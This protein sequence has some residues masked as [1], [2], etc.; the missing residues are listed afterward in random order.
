MARLETARS[1]PRALRTSDL[2]VW[3][4]RL[5]ASAQF[6]VAVLGFLA[7]AGLLAVVLPQ[8]PAAMRGNPIAIDAWVE[9]KRGTFGPGTDPLQ[10]LGLFDIVSTWWFLTA[11]GLL[12]VSV[13]VYSAD[14]LLA[15]WRNVTQPRER[16]PDSFF[17]RAANRVAVGAGE[18]TSARLE[19][20]L[21]RRRFRVSRLVEGETIYLFADR[22]AWAQLGGLLSHLAVVL[23]LAG[24]LVTRTDGYTNAL[25][26][27]EG[28]TNP[29]FAVSH[30]DQM[31]VEVLDASAS[32]DAAGRPQDYRSSLVI[33]QGGEEVARGVTTVNHPLSYNGYRFHQ[34]GYLGEGA[35]L[36]VTDVASGRTVYRESLALGDLTAAPAILVRDTQGRT[37]LDDV[38]VPTDFLAEARGSLITLPGTERR[39]WVGVTLSAAGDWNLLVYPSDAPEETVT[40]APGASRAAGGVQWTFVEAAGVPSAVAEGVPGD[41]VRG[42]VLMSE[43]TDGTP[44]LTLLGP[45]DG[46]ALTLY[47]GEPVRVGDREYVFEGRREFAG[48]EVRRD[49]GAKFIWLG[50]GL[51][52]AGLLVTFYVPRLRL[53]ARVRSDETVIAAAAER[54][55]A[56]RAEAR[57]L[58]RE[59]DM[60]AVDKGWGGPGNAERAGP[61]D[62]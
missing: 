22:F 25:L 45:V 11:L 35:A 50:A 10:A 60:E 37:L 26:I 52:L 58:V 61:A 44:F 40:I 4:W 32:F 54:S 14:R 27:A 5:L 59:L 53:W 24:G 36:R 34:A 7:V 43:Q 2:L 39:Y 41:N 20:L 12:A 29:V 16:V 13:C 33:Y 6:A 21:E 51:L 3:L 28:A 42:L 18:G 31:Q 55:G 9:S 38:I 8:V 62:D 49:P 48:I 19:A 23:L 57:R 46:Q 1:W 47:P 56:F 15:T 17:D 30:P